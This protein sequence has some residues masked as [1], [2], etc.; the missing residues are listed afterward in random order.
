MDFVRFPMVKPFVGMSLNNQETWTIGEGFYSDNSL[1]ADNVVEIN[2][3][4]NI[5]F[6]HS[7]GETI[8]NDQIVNDAW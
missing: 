8:V 4:D 3:T 5:I 2:L 1:I 7:L 6:C